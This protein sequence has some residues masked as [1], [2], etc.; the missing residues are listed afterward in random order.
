[1]LALNAGSVAA[2]SP[3]IDIVRQQLV[4]ALAG[5]G[6]WN[7]ET[8]WGLVATPRVVGSH[9]WMTAGVAARALAA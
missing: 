1:V 8:V 2:P 3:V 5:F 4:H 6:A 9:A 7:G